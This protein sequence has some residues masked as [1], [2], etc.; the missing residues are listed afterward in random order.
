MADF[1]FNIAKGRVAE[2]FNR[3][4]SN[5]PANSAIV[6]IPIARG[7]ATDAALKDLATVTAVLAIGSG[8]AEATAGGW[9]R[10]TLTDAD[11]SALA[12]DNVNDRMPASIPA[13]AFG[14]IASGNNITDLLFAYDSD[15]TT[16]TDANLIPL[17]MCAFAIN[18]DGSSVTCN[19]GD[20]YRAS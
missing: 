5:D 10:K 8:L 15:T 9:A 4:D 12:V 19:A 1:V 16:G 18:S 13:L 3:V 2:F 6:V 17:V 7:T 14:A 20:I 11:L